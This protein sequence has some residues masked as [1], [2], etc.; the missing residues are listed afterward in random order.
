[1][2]TTHHFPELDP[3][4]IAA[5][6]DALHA[7]SLVL[8]DY[9]AACRPKRK[10]WWHI[11]LRPSLDGMT[12]G[13][14]RAPGHFEQ[15][16][17]EPFDFELDLDPTHSLVR[18]RTSNGA[19]LTEPLHGQPASALAETVSNFLTAN[20]L[21]PSLVPQ[22]PSGTDMSTAGYTSDAAANL[23]AAW[24]AI[25]TAMETFRAGIREE[26]SP[27]QLWPHHF[28]LAMMWLPG[29]KIPGQDPDDEENA[30]KQMNFGFTFGDTGI[31]EPYFYITAYPLPDAFPALPLPAGTTWHS[32]GFT[33]AV[34]LYQSLV[35]TADPQAYLLDLWNAL[36]AADRTHLST[37]TP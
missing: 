7:Y 35:Q 5:T 30:D 21:D 15:R 14:I 34:L 26:T 25:S 18:A 17:L 29:D 33:G 9:P 4:A 12:S 27:V 37:K 13:V 28:D 32:D 22:N 8:G 19:E 6:R 2:S 10:H 11:S 24:R 31:A 1:M 3:A 23:A 16:H 20:G 36:L